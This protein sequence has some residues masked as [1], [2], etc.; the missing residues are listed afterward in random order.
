MSY[1]NSSETSKNAESEVEGEFYPLLRKYKDGRIERF[2][3][4]FVP[5]SREPAANG[6]VATRDV[7]IDQG[8]GVC[9]RLFLPNK[10]AATGRR[11]P[12]IMYV[13]GGSFCTDSAFSRT[14]HRYVSSLAAS[15]GS[16]V[17]SV[18]YRLAPEYPIPTAYDDTWSA[19]RWMASLSDP[20]LSDYANAEKTFLAGDSAGGNIVYNMAVR[21]AHDEHV[22]DIEGLIMVQPF[23]WGVERLPSEEAC[24]G[25]AVVFP[26]LWV[27]RLWPFVTAGNGSNDDPEIDP[28]D[29]DLMWVTCRRVLVAVAEKDTLRER[30]CRF[31]S[32]MRDYAMVQ[33]NVTVVESEGED[34]GFHLFRP[35][36][37]TSKKLMKSIVQFINQPAGEAGCI[38]PIVGVPARP[39]K[40]IM[41]YGIRMKRWGDQRSVTIGRPRVSRTGY[42]V[43]SNPARPN[44]YWDQLP[45]IIPGKDVMKNFF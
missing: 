16:L 20:W 38:Q 43:F 9:A 3:S 34:H 5:A 14:Y 2:I 22:M 6:G 23:F 13:H 4:S 33:G 29:E 45:T 19:L 27:D 21:A 28:P 17:V 26:P 18:E 42:G 12:L 10:A 25:A 35:L 37:A 36:H 31:A 1:N 8:T 41:G 30:G 7:V 11:L 44:A 24:D 39:F 15:S 32:R 40:D